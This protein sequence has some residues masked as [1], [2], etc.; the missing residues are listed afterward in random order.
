MFDG[1]PPWVIYRRSKLYH[2]NFRKGPLAG[3]VRL[4]LLSSALQN[5]PEYE[6]GW[7]N[8]LLRQRANLE[9]GQ[10]LSALSLH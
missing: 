9:K 10:M 8:F 1:G 5:F 6:N 7:L 4:I 2:T 3:W